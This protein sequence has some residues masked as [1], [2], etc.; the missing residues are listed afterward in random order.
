MT[1]DVE[2]NIARS[3][4]LIINPLQS[5]LACESQNNG[6]DRN[7]SNVSKI[8]W[9]A[10]DLIILCLNRITLKIDMKNVENAD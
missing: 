6:A 1:L 8:T 2:P 10:S 4:I 7:I 9:D 5:I 3:D